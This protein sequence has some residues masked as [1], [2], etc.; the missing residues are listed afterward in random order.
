LTQGNQDGNGSNACFN[1]PFGICFNPRD[2]CLYVTDRINH[3]LKKISM[4]GEVSTFV[5][6]TNPR[7]VVMN[8]QENCFF[9]ST[10]ESHT[11]VKISSSG[12]VSLFAG[13]ENSNGNDDGVGTNARFYYPN[14]LAID[15][16][17]GNIFVSDQL[18]HLIRKITPQGEVSTIA[19][20]ER[21]FADG[22]G[23]AT[24]FSYPCGI[25][26]DENSQ[27]LLVCDY[28]NS[29]L[30]RVKLNGVV[31]TMCDIPSPTAVV[32]TSHQSFLVASTTHKL[33]KV[34][35][36]GEEQYEAVVLAGTGKG[37]R[38]DGRADQCSFYYPN[39][40]IENNVSG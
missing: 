5:S 37:E 34:A 10:Y 15:Q 12:T 35:H 18:N 4:Q 24:K 26:F 9:V 40:K 23:K 17:T 8:F 32:L 36:L 2:E 31:T 11:I 7:G 25:C 30:R 19:G 20:S 33:Y 22:M 1:S 39:N 6:M 28:R 16:Q 3:K 13:G 29:K 38:V 27:S 21:G 14:N